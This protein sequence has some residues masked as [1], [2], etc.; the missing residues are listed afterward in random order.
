MQK[1]HPINVAIMDFMIRPHFMDRLALLTSYVELLIG[2]KQD[3]N[4]GAF[5]II[6]KLHGFAVQKQN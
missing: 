2:V 1:K 6:G 3:A 4:G 5:Q